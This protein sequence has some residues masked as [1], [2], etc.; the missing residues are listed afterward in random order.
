MREVKFATGYKPNEITKEKNS[1]KSKTEQAGYVPPHIQIGRM[2]EAGQRLDASRR[3]EFDF[4]DENEVDPNWIDPT[5]RPDYD[6]ADATQAKIAVEANLRY[7]ASETEKNSKKP[8]SPEGESP[9]KA[10]E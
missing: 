9:E 1:G 10:P 6:L 3:D 8:A 4:P 5:R 7:Q 2:F